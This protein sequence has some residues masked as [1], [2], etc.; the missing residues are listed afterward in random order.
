VQPIALELGRFTIHWYGVM[1]ALGFGFGLWTA[2]RRAPLA[3]VRAEKIMD[4]GPWL[5]VGAIVGARILFVVSYREEFVGKPFYEVFMIQRGGL[6]YYGG[7]IGASLACILYC[8]WKKLP[9]WKA[10]DIL[11][12]SV[13]LG[14]VFGRLGC[15]FN[16]CCFG[17]PCDLPW[18]ITYPVGHATHPAHV[19]PSQVYDSL[20]SLGVYLGLAWLFRRR[21]FDG[22]VFATY[23][24]AYA[25]VRSF[26][27]MFRGDY[28][29][30]IAGW[31]TPAHLV[32][33]GILLAGILLWM[34]GRR[35]WLQLRPPA[36]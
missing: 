10:A 20:L 4:L 23:L 34:A 6:V 8:Y 28:P 2:V 27:E 26:I 5:M 7:L 36:P 13:A 25:L 32:S 21:K 9:L 16:G 35:G 11:A 22:Q 14:Y 31:I 24:I 30:Y 33:A 1:V 12:P 29:R 3:G 18:A 19:H 15:L 17:K